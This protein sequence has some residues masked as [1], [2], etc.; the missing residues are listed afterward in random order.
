[1]RHV[2][3]SKKSRFFCYISNKKKISLRSPN[4]ANMPD[5]LRNPPCVLSTDKTQKPAFNLAFLCCLCSGLPAREATSLVTMTH[6]QRCPRIATANERHAN[7]QAFFSSLKK[8]LKAGNDGWKKEVTFWGELKF[9]TKRKVYS[10]CISSL[11]KKG[12]QSIFITD[13]LQWRCTP[14]WIF[15][16]CKRCR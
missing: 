5:F 14:T 10:S 7:L 1:M 16:E 3:F 4:I 8:I 13:T 6:F 9:A 12:K 2:Q 11:Q 15:Q